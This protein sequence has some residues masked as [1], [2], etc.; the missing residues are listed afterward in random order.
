M[1][2]TMNPPLSHKQTHLSNVPGNESE[3]KLSRGLRTAKTLPAERL[4]KRR[5]RARLTMMTWQ[6]RS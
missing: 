2:I 3:N 5:D 1:R 4:E 6:M